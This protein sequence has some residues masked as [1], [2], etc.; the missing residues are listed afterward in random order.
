M[1]RGQKSHVA[2][3]NKK[4]N[5]KKRERKKIR[6]INKHK[7]VNHESKG[8]ITRQIKEEDIYYTRKRMNKKK[9]ETKEEK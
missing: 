8:R 1:R 5:R 2:G 7:K 4:K 3:I 9:K 6:E